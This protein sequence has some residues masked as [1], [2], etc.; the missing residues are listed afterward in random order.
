MQ[1]HAPCCVFLGLSEPSKCFM[2]LLL[3]NIHLF[4]LE[5]RRINCKFGRRMPAQVQ[6]SSGLSSSVDVGSAVLPMWLTSFHLASCILH[7]VMQLHPG[8]TFDYTGNEC[9][10]TDPDS[11]H[12]MCCS[13][14]LEW[15][16][17]PDPLP[18]IWG[19]TSPSQ[20]ASEGFHG[21]RPVSARC[22]C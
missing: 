12:A 15:R 9:V 8:H 6:G 4:A 13:A 1:Q 20:Q 21:S 22:C 19:C 17:S 3:H 7:Q 18:P 16:G 5:L 11:E 2:S 10:V 14:H